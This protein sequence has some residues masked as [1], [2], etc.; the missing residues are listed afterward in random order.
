[1]KCPICSSEMTLSLF[2]YEFDVW[3]SDNSPVPVMLDAYY[4]SHCK[5][6]VETPEITKKNKAVIA[7][8]R[9]KRIS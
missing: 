5:E 8:I 7:S 3:V 4:C 6:E 2:Q 1:M 9:M